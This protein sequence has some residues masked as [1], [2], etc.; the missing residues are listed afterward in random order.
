[1]FWNLYN[2]VFGVEQSNVHFGNYYVHVEYNKL[3]FALSYTG[4]PKGKETVWVVQ[5]YPVSPSS[6]SNERPDFQAGH[7]LFT[8]KI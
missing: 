6:Q 8:W 2:Y 1:M 4:G 3:C 5:D 7:E